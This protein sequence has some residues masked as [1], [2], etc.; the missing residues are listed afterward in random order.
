MDFNDLTVATLKKWSSTLADNVTKNSA[1]LSR[2]KEKGAII[3][4]DGGVSLEEGVDAQENSTF[5]WYD[6][7]EVL[8][9]SPSTVLASANYDWKQ[10]SAVVSMS[11][12]EIRNNKGSKTKK[13]NLLASKMTNCERTMKNKIGAALHSDGTGSNGKEIGG[14]KLLVSDVPSAGVVGGIDASA[15]EFWRNQMFSFASEASLSAD[16]T[17]EQMLDAMAQMWLRTVR[18]SD[19]P[20]LII[21][22]SKYYSIYEKACVSIKRINDKVQI[23]D[24]GFVSLDYK[25][26]PVIYDSFCDEKRMYFL[27]TDY[28]KLR[29]HEDAYFTFDEERVVVNQDAKVYPMLFQGNITCSNRNLQGVIKP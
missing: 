20:D 28:L 10:A 17:P 29:V 21:A 11:G 24:S 13:Y 22:G 3:K 23:G 12:K 7:Y 26:V 6:G 14:L 19:T 9:I 2:L 18:G 15:H 27:N 5:K 16:P 4:E 25:G 1:L 8:D